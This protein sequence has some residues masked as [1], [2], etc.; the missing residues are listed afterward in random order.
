MLRDFR[1]FTVGV[2]KERRGRRWWEWNENGKAITENHVLSG[3][4]FLGGVYDEVKKQQKD[5]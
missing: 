4:F 2:A 1:D 3:M 5:N